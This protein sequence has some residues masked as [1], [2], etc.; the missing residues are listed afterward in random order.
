MNVG[1]VRAHHRVAVVTSL[2]LSEVL[3]MSPSASAQ[4]LYRAEEIP[5]PPGCVDGRYSLAYG[6][7][8]DAGHVIGDFYTEQGTWK[9]FLYLGG[10]QFDILENGDPSSDIALTG[11][12][13]TD[14]VCGV[15]S[16][17]GGG[18][19][20]ESGWIWSDG[21]PS[22]LGSPT[23]VSRIT[24]LAIN[25]LD[26]VLV[27]D[28]STDPVTHYVWEAGDYGM[29]LPLPDR[30]V[31]KVFVYD[32]DDR[33]DVVG[34]IFLG[35]YGPLAPVL[36]VREGGKYNVHALPLPYDFPEGS[37]AGF[38]VNGEWVLGAVW[39]TGDEI[40][41]YWDSRDLP[42]VLESAPIAGYL[43]SNMYAD[44]ERRQVIGT[45]SEHVSHDYYPILWQDGASYLIDDLM[46][47]SPGWSFTDG[48]VLGMNRHGQMAARGLKDGVYR[49]AIIHPTTVVDQPEP[50]NAGVRN[51]FSARGIGPGN[52]AKFYGALAEGQSPV[53]G[54][55]GVFLSL[56]NPVFLGAATGDAT[57]TAAT[58]AT[59]P[60]SLRGRTVYL[61]CLDR[62]W[63]IAGEVT[64][65]TFE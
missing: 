13:E 61:Q 17:S 39:D 31:E 28:E 11:I 43:Y 2:A 24:P 54:C 41:C 9:G 34:T 58:A 35:P 22:P 32:L 53:S 64:Q 19:R 50:G 62:T 56:R 21:V 1:C 18:G 25:D 46:V 23:P 7:I 3:V 47:N 42:H 36:W 12:T 63:C 57:W 65:Y 14:R 29:T 40:A 38:S 8:N 52:H 37:G 51:T 15:A 30:T 49:R 4:P 10:G 55:S 5:L 48:G 26:Q 6:A 60:A 20:D 16:H 45:V 27:Q 44:A 59:V 33:G